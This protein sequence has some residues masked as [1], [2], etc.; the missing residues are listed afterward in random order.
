MFEIREIIKT[1]YVDPLVAIPHEESVA[2]E[3]TLN[4]LKRKP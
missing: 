2:A 1:S 4:F 3:S